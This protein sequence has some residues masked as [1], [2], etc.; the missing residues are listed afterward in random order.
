[1]SLRC[2]LSIG[3]L[4]LTGICL[5][6]CVTLRSTTEFQVGGG[7]VKSWAWAIDDTA[8]QIARI[9]G[10]QDPFAAVRQRAQAVGAV[11]EDFHE[12]NQTGVVVRLPF[13]SITELEALGQSG[14]FK[15][16]GEEIQVTQR[17]TLRSSDFTV[18]VRLDVSRIKALIN[19]TQ[20]DL[21]AQGL[22][23]P[24][25]GAV[26]FS[27]MLALP[28]GVGEIVAHNASRVDGGRLTWD[29]DLGAAVG[30]RELEAT[31]RIAHGVYAH[32]DTTVRPDG[33]G[34]RGLTVALPRG[35]VADST[36]D[37]F[38][39]LRRAAEALGAAVEPYEGMGRRGLVV[40]QSFT[41]GAALREL[42]RDPLLGLGETI[43]LQHSG[44]FL[45]ATFA[46]TITLPATLSSTNSDP[47]LAEWRAALG[48]MR[49]LRY[50]LTLPGR[51]SS[52]NAAIVDERT[53]TWRLDMT[54]GTSRTLTATSEA[55]N[56]VVPAAGW[57]G[58]GCLCAGA[59]VPPGI[60]LFAG[61]RI[62][63]AR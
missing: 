26:Q 53:L 47:A 44:D 34:E 56:A 33:S 17:A 11:V 5:P 19:A 7:G 51:V 35:L 30:V 1:M 13:A 61:Y 63:R 55:A 12:G 18:R 8:L 29:V 41:D 54:S 38:A 6:G 49:D 15:D 57:A 45:R 42:G 39:G 28:A 25:A 3:L 59:L 36:G 46:A 37:P 31:A 14:P 2:R 27:Y 62:R 23:A 60:L 22:A 40:R 10:V 58:C 20:A 9:Q 4:I 21:Q 52:H 24:L 43:T 32:L 48:E 50:S 16:L